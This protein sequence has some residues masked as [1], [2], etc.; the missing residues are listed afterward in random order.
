MKISDSCKP[1]PKCQLEDKGRREI[2]SRMIDSYSEELAVRLAVDILR[3][4][5]VNMIADELQSKFEGAV[6][7]EFLTVDL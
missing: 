2:V 3:K 1:I 4:M 7:V 5:N 6:N